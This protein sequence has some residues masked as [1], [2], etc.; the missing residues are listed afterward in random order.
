MS[1]RQ[2][3]I[4]EILEI[5]S[6]Q[7]YVIVLNDNFDPRNTENWDNYRRGRILVQI[8]QVFTGAET[9]QFTKGHNGHFTENLQNSE[10]IVYTPKPSDG[11]LPQVKKN[12]SDIACINL[13]LAIDVI[14]QGELVTYLRDYPAIIAYIIVSLRLYSYNMERVQAQPQSKEPSDKSVKDRKPDGRVT[15]MKYTLLCTEYLFEDM[16]EP[17]VIDLA[18]LQRK[19]AIEMTQSKHE[20]VLGSSLEVWIELSTVLDKA[21]N[22]LEKHSFA[23]E[24]PISD[25]WQ[26]SSSLLIAS[27]YTNILK[28]IAVILDH[29]SVA[30]VILFMS[31]VAQNLAAQAKV[32]RQ[33]LRLIDIC[34]RVSARSYEG[35]PHT[36]EEEHWQDVVQAYKKLLIVSLE[37]LYNFVQWNEH[38]K[39]ML[40]LVLFGD[41]SRS[42]V[43]FETASSYEVGEAVRQGVASHTADKKLT[44]KAPSEDLQPLIDQLNRTLTFKKPSTSGDRLADS[45]GDQ[46]KASPNEYVEAALPSD[47]DPTDLATIIRALSMK[48]LLTRDAHQGLSSSAASFQTSTT[49]DAALAIQDAKRKLVASLNEDEAQGFE[50]EAEDLYDGSE[51]VRAPGQGTR[52]SGPEMAAEGSI[53]EDEEEDDD[54]ELEEGYS[55]PGDQARGILTDIPLVLGPEEIQALPLLILIGLQGLPSNAHTKG[56][57]SDLPQDL[58]SVRCNILLSQESGRN[59][60]REMLIFIAAWDLREKDFYVKMMMA[61]FRQIL[62]DELIQF[63]YQS[64]GEIKDIVSPAQTVVV[65]LLTHIFRENN[66]KVAEG[67]ANNVGAAIED[68]TTGPPKEILAVRY[69]FTVFRQHIVPETCALIHLQ[70]LI[71]IG[72]YAL[73]D[74]PLN[75]WDV[76]RVYEGIYQFLEFFAVLTESDEWKDILIK[77]EFAFELLALLKEL[78]VAIPK[79]QLG[80]TEYT[81]SATSTAISQLNAPLSL[82]VERP[83][84]PT[85]VGSTDQTTDAAGS[86]ASD[87]AQMGAEEPAEFEWRNLKK[88]IVLIMCS[89]TWKSPAVQ[90]Q[91]R[92][93]GGVELILN[94]TSFDAHNPYIREH[95]ILCIRFLMENNKENQD[96]VAELEARSVVPNEVFDEKGYEAYLDQDEK[97]QLRRKDPAPG[98]TK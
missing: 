38:Q 37:W 33:V 60:L 74:F 75:L 49:K 59:L 67:A 35:Q 64:F 42:C 78:N 26:G 66:A 24:S 91:V 85:P 5:C 4:R 19:V 95:S 55:G 97:V 6:E 21:V 69:L 57:E 29:M 7:Q 71:R 28:Y 86:A 80:A 23:S 34:V 73:E 39:L 11:P 47:T 83:Y 46:T 63:S 76:E 45:S 82:S 90:N 18:Q 9:E 51:N 88:L 87:E 25:Q 92:K 16:L 81:S 12:P 40:W 15:H 31:D 61:I 41:T 20:Q 53:D 13:S 56:S 48:C 3:N 70:G 84:D 54:D 17:H 27:Q 58:Q 89:L 36:K 8:H 65:K 52:Y 94:C 14:S 10:Y 62:G 2:K 22:I 1:S 50:N 30:K 96:I 93:L 68:P 32:D 79:G 77:W 98:P 44:G 72:N 43:G